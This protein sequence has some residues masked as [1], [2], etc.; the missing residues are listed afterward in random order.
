MKNALLWVPRKA[1]WVWLA[2]FS[3]IRHRKAKTPEN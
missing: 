2:V 1:K 3:D